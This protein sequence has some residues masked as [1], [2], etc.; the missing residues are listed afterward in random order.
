VSFAISAADGALSMCAYDSAV[1]L[2]GLALDL[3]APDDLNRARLL[4]RL[5]LALAWALDF[6]AAEHAVAEAADA[7][8]A[9]EGADAA[10]DFIAEAVRTLYD[11]GMDNRVITLARKGLAFIGERRDKTWATLRAFDLVGREA[12]DPAAPGLA[13]DS[14]SAARSRASCPCVQDLSFRSSA[15]VTS[16]PDRS[17]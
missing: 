16:P 5:G 9:S 1:Y 11:A 13:Q 8:G 4:G 14:L 7:I 15:C 17:C 3:L 12:D 6:D 2:L 10:A